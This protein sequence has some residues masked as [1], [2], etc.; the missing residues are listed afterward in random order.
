MSNEQR[1]KSK[2]C[3]VKNSM[4]YALRSMLI[5][6][7]SMLYVLC[8]LL[9]ALPLFASETIK[10]LILNEIYSSIPQKDEKIEKLGNVK[11]DLLVTGSRYSGNIE[12]WKGKGG[13]YLI[14]ELPIE[15]YVKEVVMS[16]V[17]SNWEMEALKAQAVLSR[18]Y[19]IKQKKL[20]GNSLFHI[21]SS[22]IHQAYKGNNSDA[23]VAYAVEETKG[24]ILTYNGIPIEPFYHSTCGGVTEDPE[25]VFGKSFPYLRSVES[26]CEI[27]PFWV[28]SRK[29]SV[30]EIEDALNIP[31]IKEIVIKSYT[32]TKRVKELNIIHGSGTTTIKAT[33][34]RKALGWNLLP[35]TFF[36]ILHE[37]DSILFEGRGYGHGV[38]LCQWSALQ[39][40]REGKNYR[41]ILSFFFPR[42]TIE[43]YEGR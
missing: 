6:L 25:E 32:S 18:T 16:E 34:L 36:T 3:I 39:M 30:S 38:G 40:A 42:T 4:C 13:L 17:G 37:G 1:A 8:S 20:N 22:V 19:A 33:D 21:T 24:E 5:A 11:G 27:S 26:N 14:N 28:W 10:V 29:I 2:E 31:N 23:R 43:L 15:D 35:S 41:E 7:C 9:Y 12:I